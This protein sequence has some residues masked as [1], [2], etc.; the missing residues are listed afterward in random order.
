MEVLK[1]INDHREAIA[2]YCGGAVAVYKAGGF[3][4]VK[5]WLPLKK[6]WDNISY[7]L[8]NNGGKSLLDLIQKIDKNI[9]QIKAAQDAEFQLNSDCKFECAPDGRWIRVNDSLCKLFEATDRQRL[10]GYSW[11]NFVKSEQQEAVREHYENGVETDDVLAGDCTL[12]NGQECSYIAYVKR[13][14]ETNEIISIFG[15]VN[16]KS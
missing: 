10:M 9:T 7:Q 11:I 16:K 1:W 12:A 6:K 2:W 15:I 14:S 4:R 5:V 3:L 13:N 8:N